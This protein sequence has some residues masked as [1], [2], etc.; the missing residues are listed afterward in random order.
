MPSHEMQTPFYVVLKVP[1]QI[2]SRNL[3]LQSSSV[4][5]RFVQDDDKGFSTST[6]FSIPI[7][8]F[9]R[10]Y[11]NYLTRE[12]EVECAALKRVKVSPNFGDQSLVTP[13]TF[14]QIWLSIS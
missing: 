1:P 2:S 5:A 3:E 9:Q 8:L 13:L 6:P 10:Y 7:Q 14:D 11:Y 4:P 12:R